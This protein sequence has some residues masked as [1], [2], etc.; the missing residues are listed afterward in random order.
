MS[1]AADLLIQT[2]ANC[3][4]DTIYGLPGDGINGIMEAIRTHPDK[5]RFIQ[6]RHEESAAFMAT[7]HAKLTG[8]LGCC[9]AT[10]GPGGVH[11]LNGLYDAKGD[12]AAVIAITGLPYHDLI[13]TYTQQDVDQS[14]L[15]A[16][17]AVY[18][19]RV[20]SAA[21]VENVVTLACRSALSKRGVAHLSIPVDVQEEKL[22]EAEPSARN[23]PHHTSVVAAEGMQLPQLDQVKR[24]AEVLNSASRVAILAGRGAAGA[25]EELLRTADLLGAPIIKALLGK[26]VV[27][28]THP[29]TTGGIGLLGTR[30]SHEAMEQCDA[31]LIVGSTF[32]YI[33]YY[34]KPGQARVVQ[35]DCDAARIGLRAPA[36]VGLVGDARAVLEMLNAQLQRKQSREFLQ[37]AQD[38]MREWRRV[39]RESAMADQ[40]PMKPGR[41]AIELSERLADDAI[42]AWDSGHNTGLCARYIDAV[43]E[44]IFFG[45]GMM[46]SMGCAVPY[47]IAAALLHPQRQVVAFVGD[48]GLSMLLGEL[49]TIVRYGLSIKVVVIKNNTLGQIKWEQMMFLGNPEYE[50]DLQPIDFAAVAD[51]MGIKG[52]RVV[53]P[54]DCGYVLEQALSHPGPALVEMNV[55][56]NEPLLPPK[57][58]AKYADNMEHA[59]AQGTPGAHEI[60]QSLQEQPSR[61]MLQS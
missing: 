30:P 34:P 42:V 53:L 6:V 29:L 23:K 35:I 54:E 14:R 19:T 49:A 10:S 47:A 33:E 9:L 2:L 28:D 59:L 5:M 39:L 1:N 58:V 56:P 32:P 31:L 44:Q 21:H 18:S 45:S 13:D 15:F 60:R 22:E 57:R 12:G 17:V 38:G 50:C 52:Y 41:A 20:M 16:D 7:A 46:A 4:V 40:H 43:G 27:P 36:E 3:G 25:Q 48:G 51:A 61:S 8:R 55:D 37:R 24:A 11:L 26:A